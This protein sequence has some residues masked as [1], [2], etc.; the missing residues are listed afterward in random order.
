MVTNACRDVVH[1][2]SMGRPAVDAELV[3]RATYV[4]ELRTKLDPAA[5]ERS[6]SRV[7]LIPFYVAAI[8]IATIAIA[9][10]WVPWFVVPL[11]SL[12]IGFC[13]AGITFV[14]HEMLH[15][16]IVG[17]RRLQ[18]VLGWIGFVPFVLSPRLWVAWHNNA[19]HGKTNLPDDPDS[20]PT[21]DA[22]RARRGA[23]FAVDSFSLGAKR[24]R[25]VLSL[26]LGFTVQS[27]NQLVSARREGFLDESQHRRAYAESLAALA[28]WTTV[29]IA[30]GF[31]PF[32]FVFVLP[33][34]VA[35]VCVMMFILTNHSL[36]PRVE[37]ND[38]LASG[39]TVTTSR[40]VEWVTLGFGYHV[41]HHLFP[42]MSSRHAPAVRA[43]VLERWPERYQSMPLTHALRELHRTARVYKD[44][45]TL[46]DPKTGGEF[47]TL[48]PR[49]SAGGTCR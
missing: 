46:L 49:L 37:I 1:V 14:T 12:G 24:W 5:F 7:L 28:V 41:E 36:S 3:A 2:E 33:L 29:L 17:G 31:V 10:G 42:A 23:R 15:G 8:T 38:P 4:R 16:G 40:L 11:V 32:L 30:V 27:A 22:Y 6:S 39:L 20:Y 19:H 13:F 45:T 25:G 35:N 26:I 18:H 34:L 48:A 21:L 43:L 47:E 44:A 9:R